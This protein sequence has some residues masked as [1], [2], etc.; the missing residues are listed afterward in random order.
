MHYEP[1]NAQDTSKEGKAVLLPTKAGY[2]LMVGKTFYDDRKFK[3]ITIR[4]WKHAEET[5]KELNTFKDVTTYTSEAAGYVG[6]SDQGNE[7]DMYSFQII[8]VS[9]LLVSPAFVKKGRSL[10]SSHD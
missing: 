8:L 4:N 10:I 7:H 2:Q 3:N 9:N 1:N 6:F 5:F